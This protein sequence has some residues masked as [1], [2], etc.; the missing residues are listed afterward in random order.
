MITIKLKYKSPPK[1]QEFL[2]NIRKQFSCVYRYS[3]NRFYDG[4]TKKEIYA[5]IL[6]LNNIELIKGRLISDCIDFSHWL[7]EKDKKSNHKSIFG[8]KFN[9]KQRCKEQITS[10]QFLQKRLIQL[11]LQGEIS[12][13][14]NRYFNLNLLANSITFKYN[15]NK[16]FDLQVNPSKHDLKLLLEIQDLCKQKL[17]K[18]NLILN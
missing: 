2:S 1:F 18:F 6:T 12:R 11:Y 4:L 9:F 16:Y 10:E 14:G 3:Y 7:Y 15:R 13:N 5:L 8:G 17:N